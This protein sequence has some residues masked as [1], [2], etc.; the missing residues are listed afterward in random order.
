MNVFQI[1]TLKKILKIHG[2]KKFEKTVK[3]YVS[4]NGDKI[5]KIWTEFLKKYDIVIDPRK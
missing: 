1:A 5:V 3:D 2:V 4:L